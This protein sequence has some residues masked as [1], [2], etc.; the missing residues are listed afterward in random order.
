[1]LREENEVFWE[2]LRRAARHKGWAFGAS[3]M[4]TLLTAWHH[5]SGHLY[6]WVTVWPDTRQVTEGLMWAGALSSYVLFYY[7]LEAHDAYI[8]LK[9]SAVPPDAVLNAV[10]ED[11]HGWEWCFRAV[12]YAQ[13]TWW[14]IATFRGESLLA[15]ALG[16]S[17]SL[18]LVGLS[19][20]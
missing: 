1:M 20:F 12:T 13:I 3:V 4:F 5:S 9:A 10:K 11:T 17:V 18:V 15:G 19:L 6:P 16:L 7:W 14:T 8:R 2:S